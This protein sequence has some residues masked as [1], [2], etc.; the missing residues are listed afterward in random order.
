[1]TGR[2]PFRYF[3]TGPEITRLAVLLYIR[4]PLSFR[5]V[6]DLP[7]EREIKISSETV[8]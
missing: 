2:S 7:H 1:M 5:N 3:N 8:R 4:L 6:E